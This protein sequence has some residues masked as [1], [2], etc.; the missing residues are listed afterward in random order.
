MYC[1]ADSANLQLSFNALQD[2]LI[3]LKLV[4]KAAQGSCCSPEPEVLT[5][6]VCIYPRQL[7]CITGDSLR[8][9]MINWVSL[10][11]VERHT[12]PWYLSISPCWKATTIHI[13]DGGLNSGTNSHYRQ[14][15]AKGS[16]RTVWVW[17]VS[18]PTSSH[19]KDPYST[20]LWAQTSPP[21]SFH[22]IFTEHDYRWG[23]PQWFFEFNQGL[24]KCNICLDC[25][26]TQILTHFPSIELLLIGQ[27]LVWKV[28]FTD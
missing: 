10:Q 26:I 28:C 12:N 3:N 16:L 14:A 25:K 1:K 5:V 24:F 21:L 7:E 20:N 6:V 15:H 18:H 22:F 11:L 2:A 17:K 8:Y 27:G 13:R 4:L 9:W 23:Q 19:S